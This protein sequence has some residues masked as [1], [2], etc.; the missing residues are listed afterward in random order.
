LSASLTSYLQVFVTKLNLSPTQQSALET[1][2][3]NE[4][5]DGVSQP[6]PIFRM[7]YIDHPE[8]QAQAGEVRRRYSLDPDAVASLD[9]KWSV[10]WQTSWK[11]KVP[12]VKP[13]SDAGTAPMPVSA[14]GPLQVVERVL[15]QW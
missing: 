3:D 6:S 10:A 14:A 12:S 1:I 5:K 15:Y 2:Y 9:T 13:D 4:F 8:A 11:V 7:T